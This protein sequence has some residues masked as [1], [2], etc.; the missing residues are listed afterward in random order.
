VPLVFEEEEVTCVDL[1][2]GVEVGFGEL[3]LVTAH[4]ISARTVPAYPEDIHR[5][6]VAVEIR[7]R[8]RCRPA[9]DAGEDSLRR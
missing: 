4:I 3:E 7:R 1:A 5:A 8:S 2:V 9:V 6:R